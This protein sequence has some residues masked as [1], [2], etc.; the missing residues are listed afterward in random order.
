MYSGHWEGTVAGCEAIGYTPRQA[1]GLPLGVLGATALR[2]NPF[3]DSSEGESP[4]G[5]EL[6]IAPPR[7]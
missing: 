5:P 2:S 4:P 6:R 3:Q 7:L 1:V